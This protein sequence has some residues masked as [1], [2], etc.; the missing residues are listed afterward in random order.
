MRSCSTLVFQSSVRKSVQSW[1]NRAT[2]NWGG[3]TVSVR[4]VRINGHR[5]QL[6]IHRGAGGNRSVELC[7]ARKGRGLGLRWTSWI[8]NSKPSANR[9]ERISWTSSS[10]TTLHCLVERTRN[11][12]VFVWRH[13]PS[14]TEER[15]LELVRGVFLLC[16]LDDVKKLSCDARKNDPMAWRLAGFLLPQENWSCDCH[17]QCLWNML[18][19]WSACC[20]E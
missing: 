20:R 1:R 18:V 4:I 16:C 3:A 7:N 19:T 9:L 13:R 5:K 14:Y 10:A 17:G 15:Q 2:E 8:Q 12:I 6:N 11:Q